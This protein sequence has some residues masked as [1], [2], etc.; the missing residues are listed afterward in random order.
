[1]AT[2]LYLLTFLI[3]FAVLAYHRTG[4]KLFTGATAALL[5]FGS[6]IG[7]IGQVSLVDFLCDCNSYQCAFFS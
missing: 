6:S 3:V 2:T 5:I 4:L 1:M 7:I